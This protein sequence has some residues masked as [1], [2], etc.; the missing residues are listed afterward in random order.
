MKDRKYEVRTF[1]GDAAPKVE[2]RSIEGYAIVFNVPSVIMYDWRNDRS[3]REIIDREAVTE[4][5]LNKSDV[6]ALVE[7]N[8]HRLLARYRMG[9]GTLTLEIDDHGLKYRFDAPN[10]AD[11]DYVCEMVKRGD[12][13]G[14]SF[15]FMSS[16]AS[17]EWTKGED[18][19][20][21]RRVK[22]L[23]Y[24]GDVTVT[25]DPAYTQTEVNVRSIEELEGKIKDP[26]ENPPPVVDKRYK[27]RL[28]LLRMKIN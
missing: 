7:H 26:K 14:S 5:L 22:K 19:I 27:T 12:I 28:E 4:E 17:D 25:A 16:E 21:E 23:T 6:K 11:G 1:G 8:R 9:S 3:F 20:W 18:G 10:T 24:L 15:A 2:G 13:N